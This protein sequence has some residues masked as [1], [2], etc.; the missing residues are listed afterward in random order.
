MAGGDE[1]RVRVAGF[2][3][4]YAD[5]PLYEWGHDASELRPAWWFDHYSSRV[6]LLLHADV[7]FHFQESI[8]QNSV[9]KRKHRDSDLRSP[10]SLH[11]QSPL[12]MSF[13]EAGTELGSLVVRGE[14]M[15]EAEGMQKGSLLPW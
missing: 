8:V 11:P 14:C 3:P 13:S 15:G 1:V 9:F 4:M 10:Q 5:G 12:A 6:S 2:C 7:H